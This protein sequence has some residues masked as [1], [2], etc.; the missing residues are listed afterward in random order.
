[1]AADNAPFQGDIPTLLLDTLIASEVSK[2]HLFL[3]CKRSVGNERG[4]VII[5]HGL[6]YIPEYPSKETAYN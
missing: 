2:S 1:M 3:S 6:I 5:Q 4:L